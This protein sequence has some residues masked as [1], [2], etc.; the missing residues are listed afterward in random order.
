MKLIKRNYPAILMIIAAL[1]VWEGYVRITNQPITTLPAPSQ[2]IKTLINER[3]VLLGHAK[4]TIFEALLG[5]SI[6][7]ILAIIIAIIIDSSNFFKRGFYPILVTSQTIPIIALAPLIA[8]WFGYG[9]LPKVIVVV[10]V[11]FFPIVISLA[12]GLNNA[13]KGLIDLM[14]TMNASKWQILIKIKFPSALPALFSGLRIAATYSVMGAVIGE[15]LGASKGLG[16]YMRNTLHSYLTDRLF[17]AIIIMVI[18]SITFYSILLLLETKLVPW[19]KKSN[20]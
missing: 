1:I 18:T 17:A 15:W 19:N 20:Y 8:I 16:I 10:L 12:D 6:A 9:I 3:Y 14:K 2:I 13:D 7:F 11:T 4:I 5:F